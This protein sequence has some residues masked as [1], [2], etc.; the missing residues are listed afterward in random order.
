MGYAIG[1]AK[2]AAAFLMPCVPKAW[3]SGLATEG[4]VKD[5]QQ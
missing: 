5:T 4:D 2:V 3:G 1:V